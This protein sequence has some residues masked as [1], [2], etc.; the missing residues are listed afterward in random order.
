MLE[1]QAAGVIPKIKFNDW[2]KSPATGM[3]IVAVILLFFFA[4]LW[5]RSEGGRN[6][7]CKE[8]KK[9]LNDANKL[10]FASLYAAKKREFF[11]YFVQVV[12]FHRLPVH[13][14]TLFMWGYNPTDRNME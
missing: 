13:S 12:R 9:I 14:T 11:L 6:D 4:F 10:L 7:D 1:K 8:D 3:L 5:A 2:L